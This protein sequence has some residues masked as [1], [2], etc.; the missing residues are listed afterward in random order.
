MNNDYKKIKIITNKKVYSYAPDS[1]A[2]RVIE[3]N[4]KLGSVG[5]VPFKNYLWL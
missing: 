5:F 1:S 4:K 2:H 3:K